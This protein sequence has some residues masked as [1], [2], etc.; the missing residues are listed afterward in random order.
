VDAKAAAAS[1]QDS[2]VLDQHEVGPSD[3]VPPRPHPGEGIGLSIIKRLCELLDAR[4]ELV[5]SGETGTVFRVV[6]PMV[7][8]SDSKSMRRP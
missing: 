1:G 6:I 8:A 3:P 7:Y 2:A 4:L 5:S